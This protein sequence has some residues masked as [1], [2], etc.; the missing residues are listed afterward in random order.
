MQRSDDSE[1]KAPH[2]TSAGH[3]VPLNGLAMEEVMNNDAA[4][5]DAQEHMDPNG[6]AATSAPNALG[7]LGE[8]DF[9]AAVRESGGV[10]FC[11]RNGVVYRGRAPPAV[12]IP[13]N[14]VERLELLF[15]GKKH[16]FTSVADFRGADLRGS[17]IVNS[18]FNGFIDFANSNLEGAEWTNIKFIGS[19]NFAGANLTRSKFVNVRFRGAINFNKCKLQN[20]DWANVD[21][22]GVVDFYGANLSNVDWGNVKLDDANMAGAITTGDELDFSLR[23]NPVGLAQI[24]RAR[25]G[26]DINELDDDDAWEKEDRKREEEKRKRERQMH[27]R[28]LREF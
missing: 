27:G 9:G 14:D 12:R 7:Y 8:F 21:F 19:A 17:Q 3:P 22:S 24:Q 11:M 13:T 23:S 26:G 15:D 5:N 25:G 28:R 4:I 2:T 1:G 20:S 6:V 10:G 18:T 16:Q